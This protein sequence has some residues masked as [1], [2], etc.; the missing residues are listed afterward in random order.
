MNNAGAIKLV[1][2]EQLKP[3]RFDLM[4]QINT[5][6]VLVCSQA[7]LPYL[8]QS[9]NGHILSLSPP[10]NL[11]SM[12]FAQ[13]GPYTVTKYGMSMLTLGMHVE[14]GKY[15][16]SVNSLWPRTIIATAAIEF[17]VGGPEAMK[18]ARTPAIMA[19][20]AHAVLSSSGRSISGRLL[21]DEEVLREHGWSDFEQYRVDP[22][23]GPLMP[24]LYLE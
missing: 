1:G 14:F 10:I 12:W 15:G 6:A 23:G 18:R 7:A 21:V 22:A 19:D 16:I 17:E 3:A 4:H 20:A 9:G 8:K 2:V 11:A 5:R 13:F 24:D